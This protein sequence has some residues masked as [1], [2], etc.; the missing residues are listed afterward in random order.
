MLPSFPAYLSGSKPKMRASGTQV[1]TVLA[2]SS[3][4]RNRGR[5][6]FP[7]T[8]Y[9]TEPGEGEKVCE[10]LGCQAYECTLTTAT[11]RAKVLRASS[12]V[13]SARASSAVQL[14]REQRWTKVL[15]GN[16]IMREG[17]D[18]T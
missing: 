12:P 3:R 18:K 10:S 4:E 16:S 2:D 7:N 8:V 13:T 11:Y 14:P 5:N 9:F 6:N 15:W 17:E 1:S